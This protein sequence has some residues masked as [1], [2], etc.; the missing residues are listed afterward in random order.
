[1]K[2]IADYIIIFVLMLGICNTYK[3]EFLNE[4]NWKETLK[5]LNK[6]KLQNL[7]LLYKVSYYRGG[8]DSCSSFLWC[9]RRELC[10]DPIPDTYQIIGHSPVQNIQI[11]GNNIFCDT[12]ST[13]KDGS[14]YGDKSYLVFDE[15]GFIIEN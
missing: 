5:E 10:I 7:D 2:L 1:M 9:D 13:Y 3:N 6:N 4:D 12:H 8:V 14:K 15:R 11:I